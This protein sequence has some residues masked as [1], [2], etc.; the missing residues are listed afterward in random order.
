MWHSLGPISNNRQMR[1]GWIHVTAVVYYTTGATNLGV[2]SDGLHTL[3]GGGVPE[4][5]CLVSSA[6]T[7]G[8]KVALPW[9][10]R[11]SL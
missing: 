7:G 10:P 4:P 5:D 11:Q 6:P 2:G 3:A 1:P 8:Q 9:A